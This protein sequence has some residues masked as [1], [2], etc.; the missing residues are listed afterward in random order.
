MTSSSPF[1]HSF[2]GF[3]ISGFATTARKLKTEIEELE[4]TSSAPVEL[5]S[6][7]KVRGYVQN[8]QK[9]LGRNV[10]AGRE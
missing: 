6:P 4:N 5:P 2:H 3:I 1:R 7:K 10:L 9:Y 8:L